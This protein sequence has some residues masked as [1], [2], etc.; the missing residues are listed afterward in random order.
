[1]E[2]RLQELSDNITQCVT[3]QQRE[4][5]KFWAYLMHL[6]NHLPQFAMFMKNQHLDLPDP[7]LQ[8]FNFGDPAAESEKA[9]IELD[10]KIKPDEEDQLAPIEVEG[11]RLQAHSS[12]E[13]EEEGDSG[14]DKVELS[15][16]TPPPPG[17]DESAPLEIRMKMKSR[18]NHQSKS[19]LVR[20][21]R[22]SKVKGTP[23]M[24][25]QISV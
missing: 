15:K 24:F 4:N 10:S 11:P 17:Q 14:D 1:M 9:A 5:N 13:K 25:Q 8:Q 7:L 18:R 20:A 21:K 6:E 23:R 12:I 2:R 16:I 3:A 19:H 22:K